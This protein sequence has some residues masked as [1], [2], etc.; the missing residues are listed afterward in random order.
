MLIATRQRVLPGKTQSWI[1]MKVYE[2][3]YSLIAAAFILVASPL[4]RIYT[5]DF[6]LRCVF[7]KIFD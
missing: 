1:V 4:R 5:S 3:P 7:V 6:K 2:I